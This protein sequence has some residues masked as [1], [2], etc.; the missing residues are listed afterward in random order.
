MR[1]PQCVAVKDKA[2]FLSDAR[3]TKIK[4]VVEKYIAIQSAKNAKSKKN[5]KSS[6]KKE[7]QPPKVEGQPNADAAPA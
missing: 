4:G 5:K 1:S 6:S 7:K 2:K 3:K